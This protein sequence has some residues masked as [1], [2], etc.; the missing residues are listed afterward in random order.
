[1]Q[2]M[3]TQMCD[4]WR[5]P[6]MQ[7]I[8]LPHN[9]DM[10]HTEKNVGEATF[11]SV[12]DIP[13]KSKDNVKARVD[14][15]TLCNRPKLNMQAPKNGKRWKKPK[16]DFCLTLPQRREVLEWFKGLMFP[17]GYASNLRRGVNLAT[18]RI[19]GLKSHD[20]HIWLERLLPVMVRGYVPDHVWKVLAE[21]SFFFRQLC[22][23][24]LC[25]KVLE[26][27]EKMAPVLLCKLEKIFP[28]GF[29]NPMGAYDFAPPVRGTDGGARARTLVLSN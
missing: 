13:D 2:H 11:G 18:M 10:M 20:Y 14:Q 22:A 24:E 29:F 7:D 9:I 26:E 23:K 1:V 27:M 25:P 28:P 15:E 4:L 3:W 19:N 21:M 17:D 16:A 8:L 12:M 5:L 6:Y